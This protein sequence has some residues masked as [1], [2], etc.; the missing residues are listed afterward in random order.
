MF[1]FFSFVCFALFLLFLLVDAC[2]YIPFVPAKKRSKLTGNRKMTGKPPT[3]Q[4]DVVLIG[5]GQGSLT[6][7]SVLSSFGKKVCVLEQHEVVGG[8]SHTFTIPGSKLEF[9]S[10]LHFTVPP[11]ERLLQIATGAAVPPVKTPKLEDE[12]GVYDRVVFPNEAEGTSS[13]PCNVFEAKGKTKDLCD[14]L[15]KTFPAYSSNLK[16]YFEISDSM[17]IRFAIWILS[18]LFP[19]NVRLFIL[20]L[21]FMRLWKRWASLT[22]AQGIEELFP[23]KSKEC[24]KLKTILLG[25]WINTGLPP[26]E[27]SFF[28]QTA[29][30]GGFQQL[31]VAYPEGGPKELALSL[32]EATEDRGGDVFVRCKVEKVCF[33]EGSCDFRASV[34]LSNK[35]VLFAKEVVSGIGY[36]NTMRLLPEPMRPS[37]DIKTKQSPGFVMANVVFEEGFSKEDLGISAATTWLQPSS[38][39]TNFDAVFEIDEFMRSPLRENKAAFGFTFPSCKDAKHTEEKKHTCQI[40]AP[41]R[42]EH[43]APHKPKKTSSSRVATEV[44]DMV[45][46]T[47]VVDVTYVTCATDVTY[48]T[49]A[50]DVTYAA[51]V[52]Y[53]TDVTCASDVADVADVVDVMDMLPSRHA[54][55]K[56]NKAESKS[57]L[58]LKK[59]WEEKMMRELHNLYPKTKGKIKAVDISTP[60][61]I[62]N[63]IRSLEGSAIGIGVT[64]ARFVDEEEIKKLNMKTTVPNLWMCG[65]DSLMCGQVLASTA[66]LICA[67]RMVGPLCAA[68]FAARSA[69][70]L[71][72]SK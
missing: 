23:D 46:V 44:T 3:S 25:F 22:S 53:A 5:S 21:P 34:V 72:F 31:G 18:S 38:V 55:S 60:L 67:L 35:Q 66:G 40:L 61:S 71:L 4:Y 16:L 43:F 33:E 24:M 50:T 58:A 6:C 26:S 32:V 54:P 37:D 63:Y 68:Q 51:D 49:Y 30:F 17:Q 42:W 39:G 29:I 64:P 12:H 48:A 1:V 8:G 15:C 70:L 9:D 36:R 69:R 45:E 28:M 65:Q 59:E 7:A 10:G 13:A 62:E 2:L 14:S 27:M 19:I 56:A 57:Y 52:T 20:R 11:H 47:D 41:A